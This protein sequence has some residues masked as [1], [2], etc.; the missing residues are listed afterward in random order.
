[1]HDFTAHART[2]STLATLA[3]VA[4]LSIACGGDSSTGPDPGDGPTTGALSVQLATQGD[5]PD[6][7]GYS[8]AVDGGS[9]T[10]VQANDT[11]IVTGLSEGS[12][13]VTVQETASN[14]TPP[15][16]TSGSV[17]P[18]DT[19]AVPVSVQCEAS[20]RDRIAFYS[21]RGG[22][23]GL[24]TMNPDGSDPTELTG[25]DIGPWD[26]STDG[27]R[28]VGVMNPTSSSDQWEIAVV[29][30]GGA[31]TQLTS[32]A[33]ADVYPHFEPGDS[34]IVFTRE[35]STRALYRMDA[36]G[37]NIREVTDLPGRLS[38]SDVSPA[39]GRIAFSM[40]S[41]ADSSRNIYSVNSSGGDMRTLVSDTLNAS[42]PVYSPS[43]DRIAFEVRSTSDTLKV[44]NSDGTGVQT[45][46]TGSSAYV[47]VWLPSGSALLYNRSSDV[48]RINV[49][50]TGL[51]NMTAHSAFDAYPAV[52]TWSSGND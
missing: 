7:D 43:G 21:E 30:A 29:D 38:S 3:L 27:T 1:M 13:D 14:C 4:A 33:S 52:S 18:G 48:Y 23:A 40:F 45:V 37:S 44:M 19:T 26:V 10:D 25:Q 34:T 24:Y 35:D 47:S 12:H 49:D 50:G 20:I 6:P 15:G 36:D 42:F 8:V 28:I 11:I 32:N 16:G 17:S 31:V 41:A 2:L 39:N 51:T 5:S 9:G 22:A 46:A